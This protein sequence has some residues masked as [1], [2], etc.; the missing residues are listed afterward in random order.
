MNCAGLIG[1]MLGMIPAD[2]RLEPGDRLARGVDA[3][4]ENDPQLA[5]L[6]RDAQV[7]F[8]QLPLARRLVHLGLEEAEAALACRLGRIERKVGV[9][10]QVVGGAVVVIGR[11]DADRCTDRNRPCR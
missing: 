5:L 11:D 3:G 6:E 9:A 10:H 4:L 1:P 2:Q 7:R 8:H